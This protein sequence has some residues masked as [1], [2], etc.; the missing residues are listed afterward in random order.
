MFSIIKFV[1]RYNIK[2]FIFIILSF[3]SIFF[4]LIYKYNNHYTYTK[5]LSLNNSISNTNLSGK[6]YYWGLNIFEFLVHEIDPIRI[7]NKNKFDDPKTL[8]ELFRF[9]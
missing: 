9:I 1:K 2:I 8:N 4:Y 7:Y 3:I 6:L 5:I